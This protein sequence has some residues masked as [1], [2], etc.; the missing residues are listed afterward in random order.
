MTADDEERRAWFRREILPL[1]PRLLAYAHKFCRDGETDPEDLVHDAFTRVIACKTWRE[2]TNPAAFASRTLRN[3][4]F[5][6]LRRRKVLTITAVADFELIG[7]MDETPGPEAT[8]VSRDELR[9]LRQA[10]SELP[11]Q[12]RRVFTLRK[13]YSLSPGEIAVRMGLSVS[14]VEKHLIKGLRYCSEK[15]GRASSTQPVRIDEGR[16]WAGKRDRDA[17]R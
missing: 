11:T 1:E 9:Q 16:S 4:A 3:V 12:C 5:D 10:I 7:G 8:L 13:V 14:T 17:K 2:I 15:L 6:G